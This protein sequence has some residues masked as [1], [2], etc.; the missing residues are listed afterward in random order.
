MKHCPRCSDEL[1]ADVWLCPHCEWRAEYRHGFIALAP[2][3]SDG[4]GGFDPAAFEVLAGLE[5]GNFWFRARNRLILWAL[6]RWQ[7]TTRRHLEVGCG[8][9]Y[10][11]AA[12]RHAFPQAHIT[13]SEV[14]SAG[15]PHAARRVTDVEL[16][17]MDARSIPYANEFDSIGA[18]DVIEHIHEDEQVLRQMARA[19]RPGGILLLTVPQHR[20]LWSMQDELARHVRR[21]TAAELR[22]KVVGAGLR[23]EFETSFVSLLLPLMALSRLRQRGRSGPS[24]AS[25][26]ELNPPKWLGWSLERV[27]D[28]ERLLITAGI[29]FPAGGSCFL[30]AS[31]PRDTR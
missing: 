19:L 11:L 24:L 21:Y 3:L 14:F 4:G 29:R 25:S 30:V 6:R 7:L 8:T 9:G 2:A 13:G 10:V 27:M 5:D 26:A 23:V 31:K 12:V 28:I 20:W 18:F 15:L 16:L 17:Q 1:N 22:G